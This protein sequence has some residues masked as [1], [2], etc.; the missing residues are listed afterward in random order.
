MQLGVNLGYAPPGTNPVELVPI[1]QMAEALGYDSAWAAEAW[2]VDAITPLAWLG[3]T[4]STIKLG[5]AIMQL[6]GRSP[7]NA[8]CLASSLSL[9]RNSNNVPWN[10][11]VPGFVE[12]LIC[13]VARPNSPA[14]LTAPLPL[15]D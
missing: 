15:V 14:L 12:T 10:R 7:A 8:Y 11:F 13:V 9:R 1:V 6:P 3:A 2:G 4:T 5:T